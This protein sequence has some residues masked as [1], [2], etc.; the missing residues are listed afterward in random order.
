MNRLLV[1]LLATFLLLP[2]AARADWNSCFVDPLAPRDSDGQLHQMPSLDRTDFESRPPL[3]FTYYFK[4]GRAL[5]ADP[6]YVG[7]LQKNLQRL[8]YYCGPIDGAYS[9]RVSEAISRLQKNYAMPVTGTLTWAVR[10][11]LYMP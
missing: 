7:A 6:A 8:G 2:A 10:R 1:L 3:R 11:A 4:S 5:I 9:I